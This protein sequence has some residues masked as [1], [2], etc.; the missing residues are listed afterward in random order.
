[1]LALWQ[2]RMF[3]PWLSG[4][5]PGGMAKKITSRT[6]EWLRGFL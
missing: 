5:L 6:G 2:G 3:P 4:N 1:M